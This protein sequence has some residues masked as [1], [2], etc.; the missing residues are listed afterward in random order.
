[1]PLPDQTRDGA[2]GSPSRKKENSAGN[3]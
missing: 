3:G 1:M 2:E